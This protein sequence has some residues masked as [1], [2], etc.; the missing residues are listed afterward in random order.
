MSF[1][2]SEFWWMRKSRWRPKALFDYVSS[3]WFSFSWC[4]I[5]EFSSRQWIVQVF[6]SLLLSS[7]VRKLGLRLRPWST[8]LTQ[9]LWLCS[10]LR[11]FEPKKVVFSSHTVLLLPGVVCDSKVI[12]YSKDNSKW[13]FPS[14]C[15]LN[16]CQHPCFR[17]WFFGPH[18]CS[19]CPW[20]CWPNL[21]NYVGKVSGL[22]FRRVFFLWPKRPIRVISYVL[23]AS[24]PSD[25]RLA[26][27]WQTCLSVGVFRMSNQME[28][29]PVCMTGFSS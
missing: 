27:E 28:I 20:M 18:A 5:S 23:V 22:A 7:H 3:H 25:F 26:M 16:N 11:K 14:W 15:S 8:N 12:P 4:Q 6:Q 19:L 2:L 1:T 10:E 9:V 24:A 21:L 17:T 13:S 29:S